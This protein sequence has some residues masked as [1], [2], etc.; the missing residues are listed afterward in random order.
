ME[1]EDLKGRAQAG[2]RAWGQLPRTWPEAPGHCLGSWG[3]GALGL[4]QP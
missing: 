1:A 4:T 3:P 2:R